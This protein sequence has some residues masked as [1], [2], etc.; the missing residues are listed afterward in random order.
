M[1][2]HRGEFAGRKVVVFGDGSEIERATAHAFTDSGAKVAQTQDDTAAD[3]DGGVDGIVERLGGL[4]VAVRYATTRSREAAISADPWAWREDVDR[5][6]T[7]AFVVAQ[8]AARAMSVQGGGSIVLIGSV[9][10]TH[11][12]PGRSAAA[13]AMSGLMGLTRALA[14]EFAPLNIR[15]N[16]VIPGPVLDE[17][18][19]EMAD[20]E[21]QLLEQVRLRSPAHRLA[22]PLEVTAAILFVAGKR[23]GFMTGQA[24]HVD[25]GWTSL[26]Q[27]AQMLPN[28]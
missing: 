26:N 12:Y 27:A 2:E 5:V 17:R 9:D 10:A 25:G 1:F 24:L 16:M 8:A 28:Q 19:R 3:I 13:A 14:V 11:A 7:G 22:S 4:D 6:L 20:R 15:V 18:A 23:A 21:P